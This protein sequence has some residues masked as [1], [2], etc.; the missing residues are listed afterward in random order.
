M[1]DRASPKALAASR[2]HL[3]AFVLDVAQG[4]LLTI[5]GQLAGLRKQAL[6]VLLVLG[7]RAGQVVSKDELM[8][9]VWPNVVVSDGSLAQCVADIRR[10]LSDGEH[11]LVR[12]VARRGYVLVP[13]AAAVPPSHIRRHSAGTSIASASGE[14]FDGSRARGSSAQPSAVHD[15]FEQAD[16]AVAA[17]WALEPEGTAWKTPPA[18]SMALPVDVPALSIVVLPLSID[19]DSPDSDW[20]AQ[21]LHGDLI[22]EVSRVQGSLVIARD[23]A[24]TLTGRLLDPRHVARELGVRHIVRGSLRYEGTLLRLN[25]SL[26][27]GESGVQKWSENFSV[28]RARLP[29]MLGEFAVQLGRVLQEELYRSTTERRSVLSPVQVSADDLAMRAFALWCRGFNRDNVNEALA[30]LERAVT[31]DANSVRGWAG[32]TFMNVH[33]VLT[34]WVPDRAAALRRIDEATANLERLERD[35]HYT[36]Q[37]KVIQR[38]LRKDWPAMLQLTTAWTRRHL[39]PVPFAAHGYALLLNGQPDRAV[40]ALEKAL[41]LSPRDPMR[42]EWQYRLAMGHFAATRYELARDWGQ[43]AATTNPGLPWPPVH[44]AAMMRLGQI[45]AARRAFAEH[46]ARHP[47]F[48]AVQIAQRLP[49]NNAH[50][51][52][53][54]ERLVASLREAGMR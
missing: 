17:W 8:N 14:P 37:A 11:R 54:R 19:G 24:A 21:A 39:H 7:H 48:E 25:L 45:D 35:G 40:T 50:L 1:N 53:A 49:G 29:L 6:D 38:F 2:L 15:G 52:E 26:V 33:G 47:N 30:L 18:E 31:L 16:A 43:T 12:N 3:G 23:T 5:E 20:F 10:V 51:V 46:M 9:L 32:L 13:D 28:E 44:A 34:G 42:A 36:Y 27:D 41:R 22:T 4:E